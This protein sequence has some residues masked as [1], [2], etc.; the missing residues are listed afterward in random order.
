MIRVGHDS[1]L[2]G[3]ESK[4]WIRRIWFKS[5]LSSGF[6]SMIRLQKIQWTLYSDSNPFNRFANSGLKSK[7]WQEICAK[8]LKVFLFNFFFWMKFVVREELSP[9]CPPPNGC[10]SVTAT[11]RLLA[12][13]VTSYG[14]VD[15]YFHFMDSDLELPDPNP[16]IYLGDSNPIGIHFLNDSLLQIS[17]TELGMAG[18]CIETKLFSDWVP[19]TCRYFH[20]NQALINNLQI[21]MNIFYLLPPG[22][23]HC[24]SK[25]SRNQR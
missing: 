14:K 20:R 12:C 11:G 23:S 24:E 15:L 13:V 7:T 18:N 9:S 3:F 17:R 4:F 8:H 22:Y 10:V 25:N 6:V 19:S 1:N 5:T 21:K 2:L 16:Q